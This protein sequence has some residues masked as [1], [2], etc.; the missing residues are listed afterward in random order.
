MKVLPN[1]DAALLAEFGS[2]DEVLGFYRGAL[3]SRPPG[4]VDIVPGARTVLVTCSPRDL[5]AVRDWLSTIVS[6]SAP[7]SA[8]PS[9]S[10]D[11]RY[12]GP[13]LSE[14]ASLLGMSA[15]DVIEL[16]TASTWTVAF[17]GFAPGFGYLVTDHARLVVPRRSSPR[18]LVPA[19][20]VGLAG[21]FSGVY[22]RASP[23][24]W[25]LIGTTDV[26]LFDPSLASP[27]LLAPGTT[28]RF[29]DVAGLA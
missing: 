3:V 25:Q 13:D 6:L 20:A 23:G 12:Y 8:G 27:A 19:G 5:G 26:V 9:V 29:R 2:L 16:H 28:V 17:G 10:I 24:G 14:V 15:A 7:A 21:E 1:G 11:V 18:T 22:P 4:V